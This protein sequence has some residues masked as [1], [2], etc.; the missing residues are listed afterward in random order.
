MST[1]GC[2]AIKRGDKD[3]VGVYNHLDSYPEELGLGV[4]EELHSLKKEGKIDEF[5]RRLLRCVEWQDYFMLK[6]EDLN[7][8]EEETASLTP[9]SADPLFIEYVYVFDPKTERVEVLASVPVST[10]EDYRRARANYDWVKIGG[11]D[12]NEEPNEEIMRNIQAE[13]EKIMARFR[14]AK[15]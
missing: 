1:R 10:L 6:S 7:D 14:E 3:W 11:F 9:T 4:W 15:E 2:V 8:D 13:E 5:E 12:I